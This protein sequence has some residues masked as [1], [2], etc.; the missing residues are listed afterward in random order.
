MKNARPQ[1]KNA[2]PENRNIFHAQRLKGLTTGD[3]CY[4]FKNIFAKKS[5]KIG[6]FD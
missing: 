1:T 2:R 3:R 5:A 4:D 6:V